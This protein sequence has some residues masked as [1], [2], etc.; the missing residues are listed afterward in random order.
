[1]SVEIPV[2]ADTLLGNRL[3][4]RVEVRDLDGRPAIPTELAVRVGPR[5]GAAERAE[6]T[7]G[8]DG[9]I[10]FTVEPTTA[11]PWA[12]QVNVTAPVKAAAHG[13]IRVHQPA[14]GAPDVS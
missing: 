11:G 5:D 9:T 12:W 6:A 10:T 1:M 14:F 7:V 3:R 4:V 2:V 13:L 8:D